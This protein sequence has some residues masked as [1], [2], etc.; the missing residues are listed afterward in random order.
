MIRTSKPC[1]VTFFK[2]TDTMF[3]E[4]S[5]EPT[6][7]FDEDEDVFF[8]RFDKGARKFRRRIRTEQNSTMGMRPLDERA[9]SAR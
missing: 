3:L 6:I 2:V 4:G 9:P 8:N 7:F 1:D 5:K